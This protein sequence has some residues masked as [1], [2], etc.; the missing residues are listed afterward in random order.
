MTASISNRIYTLIMNEKLSL[1]N[2]NVFVKIFCISIFFGHLLSYFKSA[3]DLLAIYPGKLIP[4]NFDFWTV[5]TYSFIEHHIWMVACN[6]VVIVMYG[7]VVEPLWGFVEM[8]RFYAIV[9]TSVAVLTTCFYLLQYLFTQDVHLLFDT[10]VY[11]MSGYAAGLTVVL[12]QTMGDQILLSTPLMKIRNRHIPLLAAFIMMLATI[13]H[14]ILSPQLTLFLFGL[15]ISWIYLRFYQRHKDGTKG[16]SAEGFS[17]ASFFPDPVSLYVGILSNTIFAV[18][19]KLHLCTNTQRKFEFKAPVV[20]M[21]LTGADIHDAERRRQLALKALNERLNKV[22][23][24]PW[25]SMEE[26]TDDGNNATSFKPID[27]SPTTLPSSSSSS[28]SVIKLTGD[29]VINIQDQQ[30]NK[31]SPIS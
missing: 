9:S 25:P 12:K 20:H 8:I 19:V 6:V 17:F 26:G 5:I 29:A 23:A 18:L 31:S 21:N 11:G 15:F 27:P 24:L 2:L 7:K 10:S 1:F 16:D 14:L 28:S 30:I 13:V 3:T 22:N 4:P